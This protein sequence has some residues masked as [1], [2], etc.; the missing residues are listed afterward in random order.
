M[1][2]TQ[3]GAWFMLGGTLLLIA[4]GIYIFAVMFTAGDRLKGMGWIRFGSLPLTLFLIVGVLFIRRKQSPNEPDSDERDNDIKKNAVLASF[5]SVW[6]SLFLLNIIPVYI[7]GKTG[8]IAVSE[9]PIINTGIVFI[10]MLVYSTAILIQYGRRA[11][12]K[13]HE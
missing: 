13:N 9:F 10:A 3:K 11:K 8:S 7:V 4:F 6:V 5:V 1:N 12:E 2:K